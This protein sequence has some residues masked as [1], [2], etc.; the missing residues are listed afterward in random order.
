MNLPIG[1]GRAVLS[2]KMGIFLAGKVVIAGLTGNLLFVQ[3]SINV[4]GTS[5]A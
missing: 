1:N 3:R 2:M 4:N 5:N